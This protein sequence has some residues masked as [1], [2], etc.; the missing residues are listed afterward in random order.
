MFATLFLFFFLLPAH[1]RMYVFCIRRLL[2]DIHAVGVSARHVRAVIS[3]SSRLSSDASGAFEYK[4]LV[5]G[6]YYILRVKLQ[7]S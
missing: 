4:L 2:F 3:G 5:R 7:G 6:K 1:A